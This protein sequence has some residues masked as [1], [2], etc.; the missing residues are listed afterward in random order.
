[1]E[2][3][4]IEE[5]IQEEAAIDYHFV[6]SE[7]NFIPNELSDYY[8]FMFHGKVPDDWVK[9]FQSSNALG[10]KAAKIVQYVK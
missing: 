8:F 10:S 1:M 4:P 6:L 3:I 2:D 9:T 5:L 7:S